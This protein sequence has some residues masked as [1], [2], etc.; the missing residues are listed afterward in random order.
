MGRVPAMRHRRLHLR[1]P[2]AQNAPAAVMKPGAVPVCQTPTPKPRSRAEERCLLP[3]ATGTQRYSQGPRG[4]TTTAH[5]HATGY[6]R[7]KPRTFAI[8]Y[9]MLSRAAAAMAAAPAAPAAQRTG[10]SPSFAPL[11]GKLL[12]PTYPAGRRRGRDSATPLRPRERPEVP[13]EHPPAARPAGAVRPPPPA[14]PPRPLG[15]SY[16]RPAGP[17]RSPSPSPRARGRSGP[18]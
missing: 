5:S 18:Q 10:P 17:N 2:P 9:A 3:T 13:A 15:G 1:P 8:S 4:V 11:F 6:V 12:S 7:A 16:S 14:E